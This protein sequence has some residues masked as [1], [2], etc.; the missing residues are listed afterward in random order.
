MKPHENNLIWEKYQQVLKE[1]DSSAIANAYVNIDEKI[2]NLLVELKNLMSRPEY[3]AFMSADQTPLTGG[4]ADMRNS[5][6][7]NFRSY[8]QSLV[9]MV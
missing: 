3:E 7:S 2:I 9:D 1:S 4:L 5:M 8:L 6:P